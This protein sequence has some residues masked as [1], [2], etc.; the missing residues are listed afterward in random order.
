MYEDHDQDTIV[1]E[2]DSQKRD[3]EA[4]GLQEH[5]TKLSAACGSAGGHIHDHSTTRRTHYTCRTKRK[6][7]EMSGVREDAL[8]KQS[9]S[10]QLSA[11][12]EVWF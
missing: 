5:T 9:S 8:D 4:V 10:L 6:L 3:L 1:N 12:G 2:S 11:T 7:I